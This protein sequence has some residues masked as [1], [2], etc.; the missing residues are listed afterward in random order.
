[1]EGGLYHLIMNSNNIFKEVIMKKIVKK[2]CILQSFL[3]L[4]GI[5]SFALLK[6]VSVYA[7]ANATQGNKEELASKILGPGVIAKDIKYT[8]D[9]AQG[10]VFTGADYLPFSDGI[11]LSTGDATKVFGSNELDADYGNP[12]DMDLDKLVKDMDTNTNDAAVLEFTITP[13]TNKISFSYVLA[14][15]ENL[16]DWPYSYEPFAIYV[17]GKNIALIPGTDTFASMQNAKDN[18]YIAGDIAG[19]DHAF[20]GGYT[21]ELTCT[22]DV[23][24]GVPVTIKLAIAD[25]D[26]DSFDTV[27]FI[28]ADNINSAPVISNVTSNAFIGNDISGTSNKN[29]MIYLVPK[30]TYSNKA[31]LEAAAGDMTAKCSANTPAAISAE[32]LSAGTYQMY[33][34]DELGAVSQPSDDIVLKADITPPEFT[35]SGNPTDWTKDN[36]TLKV[37][38]SDKESGLNLKGAYSFDG[39]A[40]WTKEASKIF[41][42]N[43]T[44]KIKVRDYAGNISSKDVVISKIDKVPPVITVNPYEMGDTKDPITVT[45]STNEGTLNAESHTFTKNGSF[46]FIATD[47]VGNK[48]VKTV[49]ITNITGEV[50][51]QTGSMI[52]FSFLFV[53]GILAV[54][55]G[56]WYLRKHVNN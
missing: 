5:I 30:G 16:N 28:K 40:T 29:G 52:D 32:G 43:G 12:G 48:T 31:A 36:V 24:P 3:I 34:A 54:F 11:I 39:G 56:I 37:T 6:P 33:A 51:P 20:Q 19:A 45:V 50:L 18:S 22:A 41:T 38:A 8:G 4:T 53:L 27:A 44:V 35:V 10:V 17:G 42:E 2:L 15:E 49:T 1:M 46:D 47:A 13:K 26:D 25:L 7:A 21:K 23:T 55:S 14:S 9:P